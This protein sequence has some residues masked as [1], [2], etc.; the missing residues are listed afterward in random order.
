MYILFLPIILYD[1]LSQIP[2]YISMIFLIPIANL[3]IKQRLSASATTEF[4]TDTDTLTFL[5]ILFAIQAVVSYALSQK[6]QTI[7]KDKKDINRLQ[8]TFN[9]HKIS[10]EH[11][12]QYLLKQQDNEINIATLNERNRIARE[13]HDNIGHVLSRSILQVGALIAINKDDTLNEPYQSLKESLNQAM[14][15]IRNSVHDLHND[16]IDLENN[17]QQLINSFDFCDVKLDYD[18]SNYVSKE[19]K[20]CFI[21][22]TKEALNN[23]IKHSN[24]TMVTISIIEHPSFYKYVYADNGDDKNTANFISKETLE[25][26]T[27]QEGI[28]LNNM[29]ERVKSLHGI[30]NFHTD[31][32]FS[33]HITIPKS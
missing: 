7:L 24:A 25:E 32:G 31:N 14:D 9:E 17:I 5:I 19:I 27:Y 26:Y 8:D 1:C 12:Y 18:I 2:K 15:S 21:T 11:E 28:G 33:I 16:S 4:H 23:T 10:L 13:I 3:W 20:Y 6:T 30:I 29:R 22:I